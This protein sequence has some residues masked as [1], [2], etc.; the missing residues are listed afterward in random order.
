MRIT[1]R[2]RRKKSRIG[3]SRGRA[4]FSKTSPL[5][6]RFEGSHEPYDGCR[7][8]GQCSAP[9][10]GPRT[11]PGL[12]ETGE[13]T[14]LA[15]RTPQRARLTLFFQPRR[16]LANR[17]ARTR[18]LERQ[19]GSPSG[20]FRPSGRPRERS[21]AIGICE[22]RV[23]VR[24]T[25]RVFRAA[26]SIGPSCLGSLLLQLPIQLDCAKDLL[27]PQPMH[28]DR[29]RI[30]GVAAS[31]SRWH[32]PR[33]IHRPLPAHSVLLLLLQA[34]SQILSLWQSSLQASTSLTASS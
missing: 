3:N 18:P 29:E 19:S 16:I 13:G 26:L 23:R 24:S 30:K 32:F 12:R 8:R 1:P 28:L 6:H 31:S 15:T 22:A 2:R 33:D 5:G 34:H 10:P 11:N 17:A 14:L 4:P 25:A 7:M 20:K 9:D 21:P 27:Q